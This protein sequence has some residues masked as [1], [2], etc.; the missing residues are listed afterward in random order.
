M[1]DRLR[2]QG[3]AVL[4]FDPRNWGSSG[5]EPRQHTNLYEQ[6]DDVSDAVTFVCSQQP[7]IDPTGHGD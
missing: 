3:Y 7:A 5:G 1:P 2:D 4:A 6:S